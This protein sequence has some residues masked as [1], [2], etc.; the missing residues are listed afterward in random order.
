MSRALSVFCEE[1]V[2]GRWRDL[3]L[4]GEKAF[5]NTFWMD[6]WQCA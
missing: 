1:V 3:E 6:L 2:A 5:I 4:A